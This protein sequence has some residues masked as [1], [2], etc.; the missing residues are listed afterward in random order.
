MTLLRSRSS[1][2]RAVGWSPMCRKL[3]TYRDHSIPFWIILG[4]NC[5]HK[6]GPLDIN[7]DLY[8]K[9]LQMALD[10]TWLW[11]TSKNSECDRKENRPI[12]FLFPNE[13]RDLVKQKPNCSHV[14]GVIFKYG[15]FKVIEVTWLICL[16]GVRLNGETLPLSMWVCETTCNHGS[17]G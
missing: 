3:E 2:G 15:E 13:Q 10:K 1:D 5:A 6:V 16:T 8:S 4:E 11:L 14:F 12:S 9:N 17:L 7:D